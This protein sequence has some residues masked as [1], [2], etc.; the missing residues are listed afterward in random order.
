MADGQFSST[1]RCATSAPSTA[2]TTSRDRASRLDTMSDNRSRWVE[3]ARSMGRLAS[4]GKLKISNSSST[5]SNR[6]KS[7]TV[8][9]RLLQLLRGCVWMG[10]NRCS[11]LVRHRCAHPAVQRLLRRSGSGA[12]TDVAETYRPRD[13]ERDTERDRPHSYF[14]G[15]SFYVSTTSVPRRCRT[16][17][18]PAP[19]RPSRRYDDIR[20]LRGPTVPR[21]DGRAPRGPLA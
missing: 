6:S 11:S 21:A 4:T 15:R 2:T 16:W 8:E 14:R 3:K 19:H 20:A 5:D 10:S 17:H 7:H 13:L 9:Y 12:S 1:S 18:G